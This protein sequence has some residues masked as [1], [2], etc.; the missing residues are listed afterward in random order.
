MKL[1]IGKIEVMG[2]DHIIELFCNM[3]VSFVNNP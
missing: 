3:D 2:H 1:V